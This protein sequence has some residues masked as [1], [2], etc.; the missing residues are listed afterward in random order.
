MNVTIRI[1]FTGPVQLEPGGASQAHV[2]AE[3]RGKPFGI[4][5]GTLH[6]QT[7]LVHRGLSRQRDIE[8]IFF[9]FLAED[10]KSEIFARYNILYNG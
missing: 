3:L 9:F 10:K 1:C 2:A 5:Q 7:E 6:A 4:D 8:T